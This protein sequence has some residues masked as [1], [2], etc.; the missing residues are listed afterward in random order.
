MIRI[1][2]P[3]VLVLLFCVSSFG[4]S[5]LTAEQIYDIVNQSVVMI[6]SDDKKGYEDQGSGVII[7]DGTYI[8]TS[9]H[10]LE[11]SREITMKHHDSE[12]RNIQIVAEDRQKDIAILKIPSAKF[13]A[14]RIANSDNI[15]PGQKVYA[16]SSP[17]GYEN[18]ISEGIIS[19]LRRDIT[20]TPLIQSTAPIAEGSSGGALVNSKGELIG[21]LT[22]GQH[23]GSLYFAVP[24]NEVM[25]MQ[26]FR[27]N[28]TTNTSNEDFF[29]QGLKASEEGNYSEAIS[30]FSKHLEK[31]S[32]DELAYFN[33]G[34]VY[35]K[36]KE[37]KQEIT[38]YTTALQLNPDFAD[39]Y[40]YR[41]TAY[42][43]LDEYQDAVR[44]YTLAIQIQ[45]DD[46]E[47][48]FNR[49]IAYY[50]LDEL[51]LAVKD[52]TKVIKFIPDFANAY[53][54]RGFA[55][56][57]MN[58]TKEAKSDFEQAIKLNPEY[59]KKLREMMEEM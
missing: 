19:G 1:S 56:K 51:E 40:K 6:V 11:D 3:P 15:K 50:Y 49:G 9:Y 35:G 7:L 20:S 8:A 24:V 59:E 31:N 57:K 38:D 12:L 52:Y 33:R 34:K 2:L 44:D 45:P 53:Y 54:N 47:A 25:K 10:L 4:Q 14:L 5:D 32:K 42:R 23:E 27:A 36:L 43:H 13:S 29:Q 26:I 41:G 22:S 58:K 28:E 16:I 17:E 30:L 39:A 21:I 46:A 48:L 37:Y 55:Y 18:T